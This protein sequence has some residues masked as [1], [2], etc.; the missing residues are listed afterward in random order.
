MNDLT[1]ES[2]ADKLQQLQF[3]HETEQCFKSLE[4]GITLAA[5]EKL[6]NGHLPFDAWW[7]SCCEMLSG[8][9]IVISFVDY[10]GSELNGE[11]D[12]YIEIHNNGPM[13]VDLSCWRLNAG[14]DGQD[15]TFPQGTYILPLA[16]IRI[17]TRKKGEFSFN[18]TQS[19]WNNKGDQAL[20]FDH[21][22]TLVSSW[23]YGAKAQDKVSINHINF[24]GKEKGSEGDEYAEIANTSDFW[25][26]V[27]GWKLNAGDEGQDFVFPE[28]SA[29]QPGSKVRVYTNEVEQNTGGYSFGSKR[30]I[31]NNKGD[32]AKL[33]DNHGKLV[34]TLSY[35]DA[36]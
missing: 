33:S 30:A 36:C 15:V 16:K 25:V 3:S 31:W 1:K 5:K 22:N 32:T 12:E 7:K 35:G 24:D 14:N 8:R 10:N 26:D 18:S 34:S 2:F 20:L 4:Q 17:H 6:A 27:S 11:E 23:V 21:N 28:V 13:I 9:Q 19:V 29:L